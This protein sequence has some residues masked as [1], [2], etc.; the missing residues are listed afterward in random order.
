V[1]VKKWYN[2]NTFE[3]QRYQTMKKDVK[4]VYAEPID[5]FPKE[6]RKKYK[7]GEYAE[8]TEERRESEAKDERK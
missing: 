1:V 5:Y 4:I 7:L 8:Q 6:I 3:R 2:Y